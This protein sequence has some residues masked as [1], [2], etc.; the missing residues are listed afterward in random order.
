MEKELFD[1]LACNP[2]IE[3]IYMIDWAFEF[4]DVDRLYQSMVSIFDPRS[5][6][7]LKEFHI[8]YCCDQR[9]EHSIEEKFSVFEKFKD[10]QANSE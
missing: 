7:N 8:S 10:E 4:V 5:W 2:Y 6:S 1:L 9:K 3:K